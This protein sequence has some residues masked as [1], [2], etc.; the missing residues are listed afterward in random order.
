[1]EEEKTIKVSYNDLDKNLKDQVRDNFREDEFLVPDDWW[2]ETIQDMKEADKWKGIDLDE[3]S[4]EFDLYRNSMDIKGSIDLYQPPFKKHIPTEFERWEDKG[5][6]YDFST[7]FENYELDDE[8]YVNRDVIFEELEEE[9]FNNEELIVVD[10]KMTLTT[11]LIPTMEKAITVYKKDYPTEIG[12]LETW[13][14]KLEAASTIFFQDSIEIDESDY[15]KFMSDLSTGIE[16]QIDGVLR[17]LR[18]NING[19]LEEFYDTL[20]DQLQKSYDEYYEDDYADANLEDRTFEVIVDE[21]GNQI[22]VVDLNS[23]W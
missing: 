14:G 17:E 7:N 8:H 23:E 5:W 10:E 12:I 15:E 4:I 16:N 22:E 21:D 6:F 1:M 18:E 3:D 9:I 20:K 19:E 11:S 13:V 2:H